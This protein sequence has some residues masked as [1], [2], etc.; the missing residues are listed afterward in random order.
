MSGRFLDKIM[1]RR[2]LDVEQMKRSIDCWKLREEAFNLRSRK[3]PFRLF[4][5]LSN[6]A[7]INIIAEIK[8]ASPSKGVINDRVNVEETARQYEAAGACAISVLT[9]PEFFRGNLDDLK[10]VADT[11][12]I[13]TLRKDFIV[14]EMQIF[15]A[16]I[17]GAEAVLLIVA[18]LDRVTLESLIAITAELGMDALVEVHAEPELDIAISVGARIVGVN[19][20]DLQ[21]L[22]VSLDTSRRLATLKPAGVRMIAESG[23]S[24]AD[25][26]AELSSLGFDGFLIGESLMRSADAGKTLASWLQLAGTTI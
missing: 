17:A 2:R 13:P 8:R 26:F 10:V 3:Q 18:G 16:A 14:D 15:E 25:E 19:N 7:R 9:E 24:S 11:V 20:R 4:E 12:F 1:L 21:T 22:N 6:Q 5:S 23:I